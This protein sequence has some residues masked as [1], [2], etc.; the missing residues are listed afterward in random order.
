M[1]LLGRSDPITGI[2]HTFLRFI[3]MQIALL[4]ILRVITGPKHRAKKDT[5][6]SKRNKGGYELIVLGLVSHFD[7]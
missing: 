7:H 2:C 5:A 6:G 1:G 3:S 4:A